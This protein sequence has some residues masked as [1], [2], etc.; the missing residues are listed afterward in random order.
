MNQCKSV[1]KAASHAKHCSEQASARSSELEEARAAWNN[2]AS[3]SSGMEECVSKNQ[4]ETKVIAIADLPELN[5]QAFV[6]FLSQQRWFAGK[7][8][9]IER[10][11]P[12]AV[13]PIELASSRAVVVLLEVVYADGG[14]ELYFVPLVVTS[15]AV[16]DELASSSP[17]LVL[18]RLQSHIGTTVL[19][20]GLM[21]DA[22][23]RKLLSAIEQQTEITVSDGVLRGTRTTLFNTQ[24]SIEPIQTAG[25]DQSNS[26]VVFGNQWFLKIFRKVEPGINPD[27]EIARYLTE[28][29]SF[30]RLPR[31]A[32]AIEFQPRT[33]GPALTLATLLEL[34]PN[35]GN[36]WQAMLSAAKMALD[37]PT[38][39]AASGAELLGRRT[40]EMHLALAQPTSD[41]AFSPEPISPADGQALVKRL[42]DGAVK[43]FEAFKK[44]SQASGSS[45]RR[46]LTV[47]PQMVDRFAA[48]LNTD[49]HALKTRIH[50]DYHLGQ[51]LC[52]GS[53]FVI[54]D[55]EGEP[56]RSLAERRAKDSPLRDVAGMLRSFDYAAHAALF[57][58]SASD[59]ANGDYRQRARAW[60]QATSAA[61]LRG[62]F[63]VAE[64]AS[65]LPPDD[66][67]RRALLDFF[68]AEKGLYEVMYELNNRPTWLPIPLAGV[69]AIAENVA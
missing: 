17:D 61:Y 50:G 49:L 40:A 58:R 37:Q 52:Q 12:H 65:F 23:C 48:L 41:L 11:K 25:H 44:S 28:Q 27:Y 54:L 31:V 6:D 20:D 63:G 9:A 39:Q 42:R 7:S 47:G 55:F 56:A 24:H 35:E 59:Q 15:G 18:A 67:A 64:G 34:V 3:E 4:G 33:N 69:L 21:A 14:T 26:A 43:V 38:P 32:G 68:V 57:E 16:A 8:R 5:Q 53:D 1:D 2:P 36:A 60:Q 13:A 30:S 66:V 29:T 46:L 62:Y 22:F 51:V 45:V 19:H 10:L